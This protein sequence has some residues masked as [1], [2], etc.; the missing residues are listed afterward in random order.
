MHFDGMM[1]EPTLL[2]DGRAIVENGKVVEAAM[3]PA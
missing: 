2:L 3:A 1:Y